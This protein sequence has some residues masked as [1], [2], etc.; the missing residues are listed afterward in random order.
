MIHK[1][2]T[3]DC[4]EPHN[5]SQVDLVDSNLRRELT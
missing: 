2:L 5:L 1:T 3:L 4:E